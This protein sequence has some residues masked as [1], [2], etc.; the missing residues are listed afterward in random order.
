LTQEE[1]GFAFASAT[2]SSPEK[3]RTQLNYQIKLIEREQNLLEKAEEEK[4]K[5]KKKVE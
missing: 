2:N 4:E 5:L 3:L 1:Q